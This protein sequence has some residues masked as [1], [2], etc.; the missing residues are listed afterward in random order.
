MEWT[1]S[2]LPGKQ[3]LQ[4]VANSEVSQGRSEEIDVTYVPSD[5]QEGFENPDLYLLAIGIN[6]YADPSLRLRLAVNDATELSQT[7]EKHGRGTVFRRVTVK[8]L[9]DSQ[10]NR[11]G[12]LEGLRWLSELRLSRHDVVAVFF[13][14][15]GDKDSQGQFYLLPQDAQPQR[16]ETTAIPGSLLNETL[17]GLESRV[18]LMLDACHSG[19]IGGLDDLRRK[20]TRYEAGVVVMCAADELTKAGEKGK[21]GFFTQSLIEGLSGEAPRSSRDGAI[22]LSAL[23]GY[24][25]DRVRELSDGQQIPVIDI[26]SSVRSFALSKPAE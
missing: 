11:Q 25:D 20:L 19:R 8:L 26:P 10:A 24:V 1:V 18:L 12:V 9:T 13:A 7:F 23:N 16:L 22:Y 6:A 17:I 5:K 4:V 14:G 21:H 3:R 2:L 15:H